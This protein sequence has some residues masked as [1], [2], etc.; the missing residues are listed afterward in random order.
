MKLDTDTLRKI[1][2]ETPGAH[3]VPT[4]RPGG[5]VGLSYWVP[6]GPGFEIP[7]YFEYLGTDPFAWKIEACVYEGRPRCVSFQCQGVVTPQGL[8]QF[9]TPE[10]LH[11]YPLGRY[12]EEATLMASR[13]VDEVPRKVKGWAN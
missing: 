10:A 7:L 4:E 13:P 2:A 11:R 1:A 6:Y 9:V 5:T 8:L 3:S 12:L